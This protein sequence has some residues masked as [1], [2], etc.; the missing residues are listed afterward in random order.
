MS[1]CRRDGILGSNSNLGPGPD[2]DSGGRDGQRLVR[3]RCSDG[4]GGTEGGGG[5][6][7]CKE[8]GARVCKRVRRVVV[9]REMRNG[10]GGSVSDGGSAEGAG[11]AQGSPDGAVEVLGAFEMKRAR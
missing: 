10:N 11:R 4:E 8:G 5:L 7:E 1:V 6:G 3:E 2:R 9:P